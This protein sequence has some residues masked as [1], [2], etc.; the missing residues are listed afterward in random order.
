MRKLVSNVMAKPV[1]NEYAAIVRFSI[2]ASAAFSLIS[3][4]GWL[5]AEILR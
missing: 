3:L 2:L 1:M 5:L 4:A